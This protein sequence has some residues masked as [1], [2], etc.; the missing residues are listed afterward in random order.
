[1]RRVGYAL[2]A[3]SWLGLWLPVRVIGLVRFGVWSW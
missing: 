3:W 1:M 2:I